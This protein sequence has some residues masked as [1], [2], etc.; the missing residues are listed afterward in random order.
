MRAEPTM[1]RRRERVSPIS[2]VKLKIIADGD[3]AL[4]S[5]TLGLRV[6]GQGARAS[7][8]T[9]DIAKAVEEVARLGA[10]VKGSPKDFK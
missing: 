1:S 5:R 3:P 10:A 2:K 9:S 6:S 4:L 8:E 7:F